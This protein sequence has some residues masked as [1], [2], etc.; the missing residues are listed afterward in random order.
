MGAVQHRIEDARD[1]RTSRLIGK[2][3]PPSFAPGGQ[4]TQMIVGA[5]HA[6]DAIILGQ[7]VALYKGYGLRRV[8]YSAF[9]PIPDASGDLPPTKPPLM[10]E[11]RLYQADWMYRFYGFSA[12]EI[13][14]GGREGMLDLAIDPKLAWALAHRE[15]FPVDLNTADYEVILRVPGIGPRVA[16]RILSA[17]RQQQLRMVDL[18]RLCQ[19][20]RKISPFIIVADSTPGRLLD[21]TDLRARFE[22]VPVQPDLFAA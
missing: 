11:H 20:V 6:P 19:S 4:S 7:S 22:P 9:S 10:R 14:S 1:A 15:R 8:Y 12:D 5:D 13:L 16:K 2:A 18:A 17:R 3:K 21:A